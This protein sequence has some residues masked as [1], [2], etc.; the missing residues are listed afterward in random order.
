MSRATR[1][2]PE[3]RERAGRMVGEQ[4]PGHP[5]QWAAIRPIAEKIGCNPETRGWRGTIVS[6]SWSPWATC[7]LRSTRRSTAVPRPTSR[8]WHSTNRA[9]GKLRPIQFTSNNVPCPL[10]RMRRTVHLLQPPNSHVRVERRRGELAV[11]EHLLDL[12][13]VRPV[14]QEQRGRC[15]PEEVAASPATIRFP[16][17]AGLEPQRLAESCR[18]HCSN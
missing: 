4:T 9:S 16:M 3:V 5:S 13:H 17:D 15:V 1:F 11:A 7:R 2:S 12:P 10:R 18:D 6:G 8:P 14:F